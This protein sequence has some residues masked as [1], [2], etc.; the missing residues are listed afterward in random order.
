MAKAT[1]LGTYSPDCLS[2]DHIF[3]LQSATANT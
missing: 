2:D 1:K 3:Y